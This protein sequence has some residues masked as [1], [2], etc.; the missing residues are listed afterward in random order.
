[1][2]E[3]KLFFGSKEAHLQTYLRLLEYMNVIESELGMFENDVLEMIELE[4]AFTNYLLL[5]LACHKSKYMA[6]RY[7][8]S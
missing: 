1:L 3:L 6:G 4:D 8:P 7:C 2:R 5:L